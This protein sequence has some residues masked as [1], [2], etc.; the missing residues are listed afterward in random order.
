MT[1]SILHTHYLTGVSAEASPGGMWGLPGALISPEE[2]L[3]HTTGACGGF[4]NSECHSSWQGEWFIR[5]SMH[6]CRVTLNVMMNPGHFACV[7]VSERVRNRIH[8]GCVSQ[9][10]SGIILV[11]FVLFWTEDVTPTCPFPRCSP[12]NIC[13]SDPSYLTPQLTAN[14]P[15]PYKA[16]SVLL[17]WRKQ[18]QRELSILIGPIK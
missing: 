2:A 4:N 11:S 5:T 8:K 10:I 14:A 15:V 3:P 7:L 6:L 12:E 17:S 16:S 13:A 9:G 1:S 18:K